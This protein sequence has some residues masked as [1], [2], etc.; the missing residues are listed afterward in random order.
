M[1]GYSFFTG[2]QQ[3]SEHI[4]TELG[5]GGGWSIRFS[6]SQLKWLEEELRQRWG[7]KWTWGNC[8]KPG[9][10]A[11]KWEEEIWMS[12]QEYEQTGLQLRWQALH[13]NACG[14]L[15]R[16]V[17]GD[18]CNI[19]KHVTGKWPGWPGQFCDHTKQRHK[20]I[21]LTDFPAWSLILIFISCDPHT[22]KL[23]FRILMRGKMNRYFSD[24][25]GTSDGCPSPPS[26]P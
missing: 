20:S 9:G 26:W 2:C 4:I 17:S 16:V 24:S 6:P 11:F 13:C 21:N 15:L 8:P 7:G 12:K 3:N 23:P 25:L 1:R 14:H 19:I 22:F 5:S 18:Q 10:V